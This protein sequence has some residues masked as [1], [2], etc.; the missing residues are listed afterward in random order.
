MSIEPSPC[1]VHGGS[2]YSWLIQPPSSTSNATGWSPGAIT[3][4]SRSIPGRSEPFADCVVGVHGGGIAGIEAWR[5][6][7]QHPRSSA[8]PRVALVAA[9]TTSNRFPPHGHRLSVQVAI[10][11][12]R[13]A[14]MH[15]VIPAGRR[16]SVLTFPC[17]R[18]TRT[19]DS[20]ALYARKWRRTLRLLG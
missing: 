13:C 17:A 18:Q 15:A 19:A 7:S 9:R 10:A 14:D 6:R 20:P 16:R 3:H 5:D 2:T 1:P 11:H 12:A 4:S 8:L